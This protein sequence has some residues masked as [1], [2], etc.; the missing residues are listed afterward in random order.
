GSLSKTVY[1]KM[2]NNLG[3]GNYSGNVNVTYNGSETLTKNVSVSGAVVGTFLELSPESVSGLTYE[4]ALGPSTAVPVSVRAYNLGNTLTATLNGTASQQ[5]EISTSQNEGFGSSLQISSAAPITMVQPSNLQGTYNATSN[6]LVCT[7]DAVTDGYVHSYTFE[8]QKPGESTWNV[9][10]NI[11]PAYPS[12][13]LNGVTSGTY[14]L[15]VKSVYASNGGQ[16]AYTTANATVP[17]AP[18]GASYLVFGSDR[19]EDF[20]WDDDLDLASST[21]EAM[22]VIMGKI[23]DNII[24]SGV[25]PAFVGMVGDGISFDQTAGYDYSNK[26]VTYNTSDILHDVQAVWSSASN[27]ATGTAPVVGHAYSDHEICV[28]DDAG[29][30]MQNDNT[31]TIHYPTGDAI[32]EVK[33]TTGIYYENADFIIYDLSFLDIAVW[34]TDFDNT[35]HPGVYESRGGIGPNTGSPSTTEVAKTIACATAASQAFQNE[36]IVDGEANPDH[37]GKAIFVM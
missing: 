6:K 9:V 27:A 7:W 15:R 11:A 5:F 8:Y 29:I 4:Y 13:T 16:T 24:P 20:T 10:S 12:C 22:R 21:S 26:N 34:R 36:F 14:A 28:I 3:E 32:D 33:N 18:S 37:A 19:H 23:K 35:C 30:M 17:A 25:T 31:S 1:V 2:A